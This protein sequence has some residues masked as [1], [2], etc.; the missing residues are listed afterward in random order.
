MNVCSLVTC[1]DISETVRCS[2]HSACSAGLRCVNGWCGDATYFSALTDRRCGQDSD[3]QERHTGQ[4]MCCLDLDQP[5]RW[6]RGKSG[7][8]RK[9]CSNEHGVP[10][11]APGR[12][13]TNKEL[14]KVRKGTGDRGQGTSLFNSLFS[15]GSGSDISESLLPGPGGV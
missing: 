7:L 12:D 6:R 8:K 1:P 9:C 5:L 3:C 13:L 15:A 4:G 14:R 2:S 11:K 10:I